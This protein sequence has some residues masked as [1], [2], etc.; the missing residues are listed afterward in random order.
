MEPPYSVSFY[1]KYAGV[2]DKDLWTLVP[3]KYTGCHYNSRYTFFF[4]FPLTTGG[5]LDSREPLR[6][7]SFQSCVDSFGRGGTEY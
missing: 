2:E 3:S 7:G 4:S 5:G 6:A 1:R